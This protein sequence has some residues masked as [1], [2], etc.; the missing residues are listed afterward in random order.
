MKEFINKSGL[1]FTDISSEAWREY[2]L[3]GNNII[4]IENPVFLNV[5]RNH[6]HRIFDAQGISHYIPFKWIH[7]R[8]QAK[9]GSPHF[10]K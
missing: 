2:I 9:E 6:S 1:E 4:K 8:W 3:P 7:L 10:V 5:S